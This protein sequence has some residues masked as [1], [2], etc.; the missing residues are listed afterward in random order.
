MA[1]SLITVLVVITLMVI[2]I[3]VIVMLVVGG[4]YFVIWPQDADGVTVVVLVEM[5]PMI[6]TVMFVFR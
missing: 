3:I 4:I 5:V 1:T 2:V 6:L